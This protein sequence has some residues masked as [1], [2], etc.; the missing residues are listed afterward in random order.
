LEELYQIIYIYLYLNSFQDTIIM[1]R[2]LPH[3]DVEKE[4]QHNPIIYSD[5]PQVVYLHNIIDEKMCQDII[6]CVNGVF[7]Q[8]KVYTDEGLVASKDRTCTVHGLT[9]ELGPLPRK[10]RELVAEKTNWKLECIEKPSLLKYE[11]GQFIKWHS[12][13]Y[14]DAHA[15]AKEENGKNRLGSFLIYLNNVERGGETL[16][17]HLK[18]KVKGKMGDALFFNYDYDNF[19]EEALKTEHAGNSILE[20]IKYAVVIFITE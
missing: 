20:G 13:Y 11:K 2:T 12:D 16:F 19:P 15:Y 14:Q 7:Y 9:D 6:D 3:I 1:R 10:I 5:N 8:S 18:L 17:R 4:K